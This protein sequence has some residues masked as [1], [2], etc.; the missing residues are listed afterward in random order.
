MPGRVIGNNQAGLS[1]RLGGELSWGREWASGATEILS[2][3]SQF[4]LS[5]YTTKLRK[6]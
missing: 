2:W 6:A 4:P 5:G 1:S 3:T